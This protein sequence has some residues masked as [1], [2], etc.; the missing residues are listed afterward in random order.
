MWLASYARPQSTRVR[1]TRQAGPSPILPHVLE[2][3]RMAARPAETNSSLLPAKAYLVH[4]EVLSHTRKRSV[5]DSPTLKIPPEHR[6][7]SLF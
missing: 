1:G 6:P 7:D 2:Q 4:H 5:P 3:S